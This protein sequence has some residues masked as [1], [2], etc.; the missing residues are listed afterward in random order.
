MQSAK[1]LITRQELLCNFC[2]VLSEMLSI[3]GDIEI[4]NF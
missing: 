4:H 2:T 3:I 1:D